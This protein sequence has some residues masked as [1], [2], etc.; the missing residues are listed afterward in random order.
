MNINKTLIYGTHSVLSACLFGNRQIFEILVTNNTK[1]K[2]PSEFEKLTRLSTDYEISKILEKKGKD[3]NHQGLLAFCSPIITKSLKNIDL[4]KEKSIA[5]MLDGLTDITNIGTIIRSCSAFNVD[6]L[7]YA[8]AGSPDIAGSE[9]IAKNAC[10]GMESVQIVAES[11]LSNSVAILKK[12]GYWIIGMD[13]SAKQSLKGF[14]K[15][16]K[17][18]HKICIIVGSEG[19]GMRALTAKLCDF[20]VKIEISKNMESL[21][22]ATATSI[23]L[24]ELTH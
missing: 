6:F 24:Y 9:V 8:K 20:L 1:S 18:F 16:N 2:I 19:K 23:A 17:D 10:G 5:V 15:K 11:N 13:G 14:T 21:N 22:V 7:I 12:N 4:A 3:I